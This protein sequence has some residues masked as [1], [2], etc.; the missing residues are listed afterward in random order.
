MIGNVRNKYTN[1]KCL[2]VI[3]AMKEI[4]AIRN[5]MMTKGGFN[6]IFTPKFLAK[7]LSYCVSVSPLSSL[8]DYSPSKYPPQDSPFY[9]K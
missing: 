8:Y 3:N 4:K 5:G 2:S 6:R 7:G 1:M 9:K